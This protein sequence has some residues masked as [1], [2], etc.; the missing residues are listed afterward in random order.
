MKTDQ[1]ATLM[2]RSCFQLIALRTR[3]LAYIVYG[4]P[5]RMFLLSVPLQ[6]VRESA[7]KLFKIDFDVYTALNAIEPKSPELKTFFVE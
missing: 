1:I 7:I 4:L 6:D 3:R 5:G 2:G